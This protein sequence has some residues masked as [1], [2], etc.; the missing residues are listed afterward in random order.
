M[1]LGHDYMAA[2][3]QA[4]EGAQH[5]ILILDWWLNPELV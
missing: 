1:S 2:I 5:E 3:A 4:I